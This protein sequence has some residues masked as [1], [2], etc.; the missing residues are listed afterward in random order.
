MSGVPSVI[1][2]PA[3]QAQPYFA[4]YYCVIFTYPSTLSTSITSC[5]IPL[6]VNTLS[7]WCSTLDIVIYICFL[8]RR[9]M[10]SKEPETLFTIPIGSE[11][12]VVC[13]RPADRIYVLEFTSP[14]D[15]RLV[16]VT[17]SCLLE[18][19]CTSATL[20]LPTLYKLHTNR[21]PALCLYFLQSLLI[22]LLT[23][24]P[25]PSS[26]TLLPTHRKTTS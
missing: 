3:W 19:F 7:C 21:Y 17:A 9:T 14:P 26:P 8:P 1:A 10:S 16:T 22:P 25:S 2:V 24:R 15:N 4:T 20:Y 5:T 13:L 12:Q 23:P 11:G 6:H 18:I